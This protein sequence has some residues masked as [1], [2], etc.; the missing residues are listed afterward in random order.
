MKRFLNVLNLSKEPKQ[1][2]FLSEK[3]DM[4]IAKKE[5]D[6][7]LDEIDWDILSLIKW[8]GGKTEKYSNFCKR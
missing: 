4:G 2:I 8:M 1:A 3:G 7:Q 5:M 6:R